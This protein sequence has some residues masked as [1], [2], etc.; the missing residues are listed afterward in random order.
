MKTITLVSVE[1]TQFKKHGH[2]VVD[3]SSTLTAIRGPNYA[4]KS[5]VLDAIFFAQFGVSA[6][7]GSKETIVQK[8]HTDCKVKLHLLVDDYEA[9]I[10][11][12]LNTASVVVDG[13][14]VATGHTSVTGYMASLYGMSPDMLLN[15]AYSS[16]EEAS[17]LL[18]LGPSKLNSMIEEIS[19]VAYVDAMVEKAGAIWKAA[20]VK[21]GVLPTLRDPAEVE[22]ERAAALAEVTELINVLADLEGQE[23]TLKLQVATVS[24]QLTDASKH[25]EKAQANN[26][27]R[28]RMLQAVET[29]RAAHLQASLLVATA[30]AD[31]APLLQAAQDAVEDY[32]AANVQRTARKELQREGRELTEKLE[33]AK[34]WAAKEAEVDSQVAPLL[35]QQESLTR[36]LEE[37]KKERDKA[38]DNAEDAR[39]SRCSKCL[40]PFDLEHPA[41]DL[42]SLISLFNRASEA[43]TACRDSLESVVATI[44]KL[45]NSH[46]P[47]GWRLLKASWDKR[48]EE[49]T[50]RVLEL[51]KL[52]EQQMHDL[53]KSADLAEGN[54]RA[55][56][57]EWQRH[58]VR[59]EQFKAAENELERLESLPCP[60]EM[61]VT[62]VLQLVVHLT[63]LQNKYKHVFETKG[64]RAREWNRA[65]DLYS[66][67]DEELLTIAKT[68]EDRKFLET[69]VARFKAFQTW[70]RS[71]KATFMDDVWQKLS[72]LMS[73]FVSQVT[74]GRVERIWRE[75]DGAFWYLEDEVSKPV[76]GC[77]SKGQR[78]MFNAALRIAL[79][80]LLP[81]ACGY[82]VLDEPGAN[83]DNEHAAALAGALRAQN[84]QV[85]LVTHREGDEFAA[86][87]VVLLS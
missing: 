20:E 40:R 34:G 8:G 70:L 67:R 84:R 59:L 43:V 9:T 19:D 5:S 24:E 74:S 32:R 7:T 71:N 23:E 52:T 13:K 49:L 57:S 76:R 86:D 55:A 82:I 15:L 53:E 47:S 30:P 27:K 41:P 68:S 87:S 29:A 26:E 39:S 50:A 78:A 33:Q 18:A 65:A 17:A 16:E 2:L 1:L 62:S 48:V 3:F 60:P 66:Q 45:R 69:R 72:Y 56:S 46:P 54:Y 4:G 85:V 25:N 58:Q 63:D 64:Q 37:L 79:A 10:T 81:Q 83:L 61:P 75:T 38:H 42:P 14:T 6:V 28:N 22:Q 51:P 11:R 73:E 36:R 31:P 12:T 21:L 35:Q 80:A 77:A 44:G